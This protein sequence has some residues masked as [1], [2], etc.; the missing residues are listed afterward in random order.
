MNESE[1]ALEEEARKRKEIDV[2]IMRLD[3]LDEQV[4]GLMRQD[5]ELKARLVRIERELGEI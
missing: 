3:S 1:A 2:I 4:A 5:A